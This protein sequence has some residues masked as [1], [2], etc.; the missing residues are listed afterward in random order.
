MHILMRLAEVIDVIPLQMRI[1][2]TG[3]LESSI[4]TE[5]AA[6]TRTVLKQ[7]AAVNKR[8]FVTSD[9]PILWFSFVHIW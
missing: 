5:M 9:I 7:Q 4:R 2:S 8:V 1:V 6:V 3:I